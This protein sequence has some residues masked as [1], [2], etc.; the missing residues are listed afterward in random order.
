MANTSTATKFIPLSVPEIRGNEWSYVK[1][2]LDTGWVSSVGEYVNRFECSIAKKVRAQSGV[3]TS[4]GT[5]ALHIALLVSGVQPDDEVLVSTLT[6]IAPVNAIRYAGAWPVL[7]DAEPNF[8]QINPDK[9]ADFLKKNCRFTNGEL[10]N[11]ASGRRIRAVMP[12]HILGHPVDLDPIRVIAREFDL[13]VI[14]DATE[15]L[16]AT[17]RGNRIGAT[18]EIAC[19]SFN[20]N[21][22]ITTGGGGAIVTSNAQWA[23]RARYLTTQAKDD[24]VEFVHGTVGYNYRLTNIQAALGCAQLEKLDEFIEKKRSIASRYEDGFRNIAGVTL[25]RQAAWAESIFWLYTILIDEAEF[26][27]DSRTLLKK[28]EERGIQ[29]R[30]LWQ[31]MHRSPVHRN[32]ESFHCE[33]ADWI[34]ARALS[35]PCSVGLTESDQ[36]LVIQTVLELGK[37]G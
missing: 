4:S 15:C 26:G 9:V 21:K 30:P 12:V 25:M 37:Q 24:P 28:L 32:H 34:H 5:S 7:M 19:F 27:M 31:P 1:E 2:C 23:D 22:I 29:T 6:F 18:S 35:L 16:G 36:N 17:Y 13:S 10:R 11:R 8:W 3:A 14:E 20:G 33:T